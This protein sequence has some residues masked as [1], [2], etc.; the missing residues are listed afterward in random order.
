MVFQEKG[1]RV[2]FTI[3]I[4]GTAAKLCFTINEG[5]IMKFVTVYIEKDTNLAVQLRTFIK[6]ILASQKDCEIIILCN[7]VPDVGFSVPDCVIFKRVFT[8]IG[9]EFDAYRLKMD[10]YKYVD[11]PYLYL[12][13]DCI[14]SGEI[15]ATDMDISANVIRYNRPDFYG[16]EIEEV[17]K[18]F[19]VRHLLY[20]NSGTV[21]CNTAR[22]KELYET[23]AQLMDDYSG[24][25]WKEDEPYLVIA[26]SKLR[27][28]ER[29]KIKYM[30][31]MST[32]WDVY[33]TKAIHHYHC[34]K[35][36]P[37]ASN[38]ITRIL[39]VDTQFGH[40]FPQT[41]YQFTEEFEA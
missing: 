21:L 26:L 27:E 11:V 14:V 32:A 15:P 12:D 13:S 5:K 3:S 4:A 35:A 20:C 24:T 7:T 38:L 40:K 10:V 2:V 17:Q 39:D 8:G 23:A 6:S 41:V 34:S 37:V 29:I 36:S 30:D 16:H 18:A 25:W 28:Q 31:Y 22:S 33:D 9:T 19:G 1:E